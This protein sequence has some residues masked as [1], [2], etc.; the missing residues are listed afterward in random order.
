TEVMA[1]LEAKCA[2]RRTSVAASNP[3]MAGRSPLR[4]NASHAGS[5]PRVVL[6]VQLL[7]AG[8]GD[9]GVDLGGGQVAMPQQ[10]LP[11]PQVGAMVEQ[12]GGEGMAQGVWRQRLADAGHPG[13][14]LDAVPEGLAG[15]LLAAQAGEQ[16][17]AG[18]AVE[19]EGPRLAQVAL[20]PG[21]GLLAQ[22]HQALLAALAEYPQHALAQVD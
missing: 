6:G 11:R 18:P 21:D 4:R 17:V 7:Q 3:A 14:V 19:Q 12:M 10:H 2:A 5:S 1:L 20:D 15:H 16:H 22:R 13:L 8:T 9:M